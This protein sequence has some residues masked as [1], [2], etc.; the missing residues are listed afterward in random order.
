MSTALWPFIVY[1]AAVIAVVTG[2]IAISYFLG[3]RHREK[4][5]G[6]PYE[7]GIVSTGSAR[8]RFS[9]RFYLVALFF[10]IIDV[11]SIFIFAWAIAFKELG[12]TGYIGVLVFITVLLAMLVYLWRTGGLD[13]GDRKTK[14]EREIRQ[15]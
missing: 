6:K 1:S 12:L 7:S 9:I 14:Q 4:A 10:V 15:D 13:W 8:Q 3:E 11:E 5:T 2:M